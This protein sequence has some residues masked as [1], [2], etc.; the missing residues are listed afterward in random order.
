MK[1]LSNFKSFKIKYAKKNIT[2]VLKQ[3]HG[4]NHKNIEKIKLMNGFLFQR[5]ENIH[6]KDYDQIFSQSNFF[7]NTE[8]NKIFYN[9]RKW[10]KIKNYKGMRHVL[11]LPVRG[12]RTHTNSSNMKKCVKKEMF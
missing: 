11:K 2:N 6:L 7:Y 12:Q 10:V 1:I 5:V 8:K 3:V 4:L 9:V